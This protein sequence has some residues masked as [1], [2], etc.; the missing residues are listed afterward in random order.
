MYSPN[1]LCS[2]LCVL[3]ICSYNDVQVAESQGLVA[4]D[5]AILVCNAFIH[6]FEL[7]HAGWEVRKFY[8]WTLL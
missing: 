6:N 1:L 5:D 8:I 2:F 3:S 7:V 4:H